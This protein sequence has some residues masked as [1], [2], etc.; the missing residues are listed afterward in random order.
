M[1][2]IDAV[3]AA[4][5]LI[6][7]G[8]FFYLRKQRDPAFVMDLSLVYLVVM[9]FALGVMMHGGAARGREPG[10]EPYDH[11]DRAGDPDGR[12]HRSSHALEN[13]DRRSPGRV[14]GS[15]R[16]RTELAVPLALDHV[17][18]ACLAKRPENRP[19]TATELDRMLAE[20]AVEPWTEEQ[21][22]R[23][24]SLRGPSLIAAGA[25]NPRAIRLRV[26]ATGGSATTPG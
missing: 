24:W 1:Q 3:A 14:H 16:Q 21:A 22:E 25:A 7:L 19:G 23:W 11:V 18:L 17:I 26:A 13:A 8:L 10:C 15:T 5:V 2:W 6:S 12:G 9:A 20:I 4:S